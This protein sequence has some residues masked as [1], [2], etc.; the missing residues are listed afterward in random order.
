MA[1]KVTAM[2]CRGR[3]K[4]SDDFG[5]EP[6]PVAVVPPD[7]LE[8]QIVDAHPLAVGQ[9]GH[10]ARRSE[11]AGD[12]NFRK[13]RSGALRCTDRLDGKVCG[14]RS[15]HVG[16]ANIGCLGHLFP[17]SSWPRRRM[18]PFL[19]RAVRTKRSIA[20]CEE[21]GPIAVR[22]FLVT[23]FDLLRV[24]LERRA[25]RIRHREARCAGL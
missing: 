14:R 12:E 6:V 21:A 20:F 7:W 22:T 19:R 16:N 1:G 23:P 10:H 11:S 3:S 25:T 13:P 8:D 5:S 9:L 17:W 24:G 15:G 2:R 4:G 18:R